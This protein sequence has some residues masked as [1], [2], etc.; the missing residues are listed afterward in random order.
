MAQTT[1]TGRLRD[2]RMVRPSRRAAAKPPFG[3]ALLLILALVVQSGCIALPPD[4]AAELEPARQD[5]PNH[6]HKRVPS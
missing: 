5:R 3:P 2:E 1:I 4:V 6:F